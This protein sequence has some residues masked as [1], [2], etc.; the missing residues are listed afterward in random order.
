MS[1]SGCTMMFMT[2]SRVLNIRIW[3]IGSV[4]VKKWHSAQ[5]VLSSVHAFMASLLHEWCVILMMKVQCTMEAIPPIGYFHQFLNVT[6]R[7][8]QHN[9]KLFHLLVYTTVVFFNLLWNFKDNIYTKQR[10]PLAS[11]YYWTNLCGTYS[12]QDAY[13]FI[14]IMKNM[15]TGSLSRVY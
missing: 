4:F 8:W 1:V 12:L 2:F 11:S 10:T 7:I 13:T 3:S 9:S 5:I 14:V 15:F 6:T